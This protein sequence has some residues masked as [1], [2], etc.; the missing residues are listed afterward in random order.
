M[1][2]HAIGQ[3]KQAMV[4]KSHTVQTAQPRTS[5]SF[6][7]ANLLPPPPR[8]SPPPSQSMPASASAAATAARSQLQ[9]TI[10]KS[11][12]LKTNAGVVP[13]PS[14]S[15]FY[16][17]GIT[18]KPVHTASTFH[19]ARVYVCGENWKR[20][21]GDVRMLEDGKCDFG[22]KKSDTSILSDRVSSPPLFFCPT[23]AGGGARDD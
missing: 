12:L 6:L 21:R 5:I 14:P 22:Y 23:Q 11:G 13:R 7:T 3:I 17:P 4:R 20:G 8:P 18:S 2:G 19:W 15:L 16:F 10:V 1:Y 9:A